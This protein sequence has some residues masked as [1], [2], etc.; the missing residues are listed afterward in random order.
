MASIFKEFEIVIKDEMEVGGIIL[1]FIFDIKNIDEVE[2]DLYNLANEYRNY[3]DYLSKIN[4]LEDMCRFVDLQT[5]QIE[6]SEEF[7]QIFKNN[8]IN[9]DLNDSSNIILSDVKSLLKFMNI[10][11]KLKDSDF[12][13]IK[14]FIEQRRTRIIEEFITRVRT[15]MGL[16][17][18]S[19]KFTE[20]FMQIQ[21]ASEFNHSC[22]FPENMNKSY[23]E[24]TFR[25][26]FLKRVYLARKY[27]VEERRTRKLREDL[28]GGKNKR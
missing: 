21:I 4:T 14:L 18:P 10:I 19:E 28:K 2:I 8:K 27:E 12:A 23:S 17:D 1:P 20:A 6:Y 24:Y 7:E 5:L 3:N 25:E 11:L 9:F 26:K 22:I 15:L 16:N 13:N